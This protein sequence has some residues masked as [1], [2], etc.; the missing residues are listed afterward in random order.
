MS[1][2]GRWDIV[3]AARR[4]AAAVASGALR[5]EDIDEAALRAASWRSA[6]MPDPDLFIRT[7][8]DHRISNFLLWNLAYTELLCL[9]HVVAGFRRAAVR[10]G[11]G[12]IRGP[13][14]PLRA[15]R[16]Q[17]RGRRARRL[18]VLRQRVLTAMVLVAV[19]LGVMLGLPPIATIWL[20][21]VLVLIGAWEWAAFIG[22]AAP[23]RARRSR[24]SWRHC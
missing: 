3:Q 23:R 10:G 2:G 6:D 1:Y 12:V 16:D 14:A 17:A 4:L 18:A 9:R 11:A 21:T 24:W 8:G 7:G 13:R 20:V 5:P 22:K 19:L 15:H